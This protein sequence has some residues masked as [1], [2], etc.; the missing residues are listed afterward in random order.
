MSNL[1]SLHASDLNASMVIL[2]T[3]VSAGNHGSLRVGVGSRILAAAT[4]VSAGDVPQGLENR[5][6]LPNKIKLRTT[7]RN[8]CDHCAEKDIQGLSDWPELWCSEK[9]QIRQM[10]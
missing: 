6:L 10:I 7:T 4:D 3:V 8:G 9:T 5:D 1:E 2:C